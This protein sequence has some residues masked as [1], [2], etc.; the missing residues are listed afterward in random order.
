MSQGSQGSGR[1]WWALVAACFGLFMALLDITI[2]LVAL[3][4]IQTSLKV[5]FSN[6]QWVINAYSLIFAVLLVPLSRLGDILGR[7]RIFMMGLGVFSLGSLLCALSGHISV[8]GLSAASMLN[9]FR[10]LQG[11]GS[12]AMMPLS[13]AIVSATFSGPERSTAI[14]IW[15]G[16]SAIATA[17]GPLLGGY[18]VLHFGWESIF[19]LNVP[20]GVVGIG[21]SAWAIR[22]SRDEKAPKTIDVFGISTF[23]IAVFCLILALIQGNSVGWSSEEILLLFAGFIVFLGVFVLGEVRLKHP[24]VDPRLFRIPSY[25]GSCV[26]VFVI[27][28]G[29]YSLLFFLTLYFQD[30]LGMS[31][32]QAGLRFLPLSGLVII[33]APLSGRLSG[34]FGPRPFILT[35][36]VLLTASVLWMTTIGTSLEQSAWL[37]LLPAFIVGGIGSGMLNP[38]ASELAVGTVP[39][40]RVGMGSGVNNISRQVGIGFGIAFLGALLNIRYDAAIKSGI[41]ALPKSV[42]ATAKSGIVSGLQKAGVIAGSTGFKNAGSVYTHNP[43]FPT[44]QKVGRHAFISGTREVLFVAALLLFLGL[45]AC[46]FLIRKGPLHSMEDSLDGQGGPE[47]AV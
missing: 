36:L 31:A 8:F 20:I 29:F 46:F 45:V 28:A 34:R 21:L 32:L 22:E 19:Y 42:P 3:P 7:K 17:I 23:T 15:G 14:G 35:S 30:Y 24:M 2:V 26:A 44:I 33:G 39:P 6:L 13:L 47:G 9:V 38:P 37:T 27:S 4:K 10:G 12:A 43:L 16:V 25:T 5:P 18:L 1:K 40:N 41:Y 11:V